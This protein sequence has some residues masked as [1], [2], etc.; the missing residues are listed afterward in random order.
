M[1]YGQGFAFATYVHGDFPGVAAA[2]AAWVCD[3]AVDLETGEISLTR[4]FVGQDRG[5]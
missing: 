3:V 4:V 1:A 5:L 2:T